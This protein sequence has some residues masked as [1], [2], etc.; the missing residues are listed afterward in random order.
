MASDSL[1]QIGRNI[2]Q[3]NRRSELAIKRVTNNIPKRERT[4]DTVSSVF[5]FSMM[6]NSEGEGERFTVS[7]NFNKPP[8]VDCAAECFAT[9]CEDFSLTQGSYLL[10]TTNP[11]E[12]ETVKVFSQGAVLDPAQWTEENP[13]AGQVYVQVQGGTEIIVI[14]YMY[15]IC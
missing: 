2:R 1:N 5:P 15:I 4:R 9:A 3:M 7:I 12:A 14:C 8:P 13:A 6:V 10:Q 11:Y